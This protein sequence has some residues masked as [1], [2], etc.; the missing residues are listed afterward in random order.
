MRRRGVVGTT[1]VLAATAGM[2]VPAVAPVPASADTPPAVSAPASFTPYVDTT[3]DP[4]YD[5][6]G[7]ANSTGVKDFNLAFVVSGGGCT[8]EWGGIN[9]L[10]HDGVL[11]QIDQLRQLGGD[12][13]VSFGG[14]H[15]T[16]LAQACSTATSLADAY[17]QVI[18]AYGVDKIDVDVEGAALPDMA[19]NT[20]RNQAIAGLQRAATAGHPLDVSFTLPVLPSGLTQDDLDLLRDAKADGVAVTAVNVM[21]MD[22]GDGAAPS[23]AGRMGQYAIDAATATQAQLKDLYGINDTQAWQRIAVTPM[24]GVND[25]SDEM[26][27]PADAAQLAAFAGAKHLAWLS[28]WSTTRDQACTAGVVD[29]ALPTCSGV[30]QQP[31]D[32]SRTL[33]E[34][35]G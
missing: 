13:R 12:V 11:G 16:E 29:A 14:A 32:F 19:A 26:F 30:R 2:L 21:A 17:Q 27:T 15:G 24:I 35:T 20:R 18:T 3:L 23:P 34:Y 10:N 4:P 33:D 6:I 31:L 28:M 9:E 25:A 8:P 1:V 7:A 22:Y 5:L